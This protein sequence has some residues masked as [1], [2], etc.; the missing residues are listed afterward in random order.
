M[1]LPTATWRK[2]SR[3]QGGGNNCIEVAVIPGFIAIR[4]S[5][6]PHGPV[7]IISPAA[8]RD[9]VTQIKLGDFDL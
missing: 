4:D 7:H 5:K 8:F 3:S 1:D 6:D 9:L 2:S